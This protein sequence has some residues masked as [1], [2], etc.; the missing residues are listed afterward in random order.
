MCK[1]FGYIR[2]KLERCLSCVISKYETSNILTGP[3]GRG[4][5][6]DVCACVKTTMCQSCPEPPSIDT[7]KSRNHLIPS[8]GFFN[9]IKF[10]GA[11]YLL[12]NKEVYEW[13]LITIVRKFKL[14][15]ERIHVYNHNLRSPL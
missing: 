5:E 8:K 2:T 4:K 1:D 10:L 12:S 13:L 15:S 7:H 14:K 11:G 3:R 9:M 6:N